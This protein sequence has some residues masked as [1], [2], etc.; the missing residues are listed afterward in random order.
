[1]LASRRVSS[2]TTWAFGNHESYHR[3]YTTA[4]PVGLERFTNDHAE[5]MYLERSMT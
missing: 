3:A 2:H 4:Y 1:M 5:S